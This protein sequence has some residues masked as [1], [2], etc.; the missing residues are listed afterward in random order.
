M[1]ELVPK[2]CTGWFRFNKKFVYEFYFEKGHVIVL[3]VYIIQSFEFVPAPTSRYMIA[4]EPNLYL[5]I[6]SKFL[7][8]TKQLPHKTQLTKSLSVTIMAEMFSL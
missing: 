7:E 5:Q 1:N 8:P 6:M 4:K 2:K 3:I